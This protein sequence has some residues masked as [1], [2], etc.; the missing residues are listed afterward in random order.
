MKRSAAVNLGVVGALGVAFSG[1]GEEET[2]YCTDANQVVVENQFCGD[3][4]DGGGSAFFLWYGG[5]VGNPSLSKG[6]RVPA[7]GETVSSLDKSTI[8]N[9]GGFGK[10]AGSGVGRTVSRG[11]FGGFGGGG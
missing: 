1:C 4:D 2:V 9:K 10:S 11:G 6:Q 5:R 7:G 3:D 8:R